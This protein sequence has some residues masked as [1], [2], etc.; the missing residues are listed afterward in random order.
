MRPDERIFVADR[1]AVLGGRA[2][3]R[4]HMTRWIEIADRRHFFEATMESGT[5]PEHESHFV[6]LGE[7]IADISSW[8]HRHEF[9]GKQLAVSNYAITYVMHAAPITSNAGD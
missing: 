6:H 7:T 3:S 4:N 5:D 1:D 2:M 8:A 9:V